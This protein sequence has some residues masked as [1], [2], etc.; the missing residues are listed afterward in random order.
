M[1]A[2]AEFIDNLRQDQSSVF[3]DSPGGGVQDVLVDA[4]RSSRQ[5]AIYFQDEI[6]IK[7]SIILNGGLRYDGYEQ[8]TRVTPRAALIVLPSANQ[9]FKYLFGRAFRAPSAYE[10]T[11]FYFGDSVEQLQPESIDTHELVWE[12]YFNDALRTSVSTYWYKADRLLTLVPDDTTFLGARYVNA[13]EVH[14]S[15]VEFEGAAPHHEQ[16]AGALQLRAAAHRRSGLA[17]RAS[18]LPAPHGER[19]AQLSPVRRVDLR[20][21]SK[22]CS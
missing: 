21:V 19:T 5:H 22:V 15:G 9:S 1:T 6:R 12:R 10:S 7:D 20:S 4:P 3:L 17:D 8:F 14:A 16:R 13:G 11:T 18:Q 2:G